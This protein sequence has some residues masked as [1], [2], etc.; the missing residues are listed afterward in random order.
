MNEIFVI[1]DVIIKAINSKTKT[2]NAFLKS[3]LK[4]YNLYRCGRIDKKGYWNN[5]NHIIKTL[6]DK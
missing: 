3:L 4:N 1:D 2:K 5:M 6:M